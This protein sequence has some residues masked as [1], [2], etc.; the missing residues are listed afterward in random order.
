MLELFAPLGLALVAAA[1]VAVLGTRM[2]HATAAWFTAT[3]IT[4]VLVAG[5]A[6]SW[7]LSLGFISHDPATEEPQ[8]LFVAFDEYQE[9]DCISLG[10]AED[11]HFLAHRCRRV[12][13]HHHVFT[14]LNVR[15]P[16]LDRIESHSRIGWFNHRF[17]FLD[18]RLATFHMSGDRPPP[19]QD[20]NDSSQETKLGRSNI[21]FFSLRP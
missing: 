4:S 2:R 10:R 15:P 1:L 18:T 21:R 9:G 12:T 11:D 5:M 8:P 7:L 20:L 3:S 6:R 19:F 14:F 17:I 13:G 16:G